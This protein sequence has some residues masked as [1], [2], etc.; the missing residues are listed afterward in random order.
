RASQDLAAAGFEQARIEKYIA[1]M[2]ELS[3]EEVADPKQLQEHSNLIAA[4]LALKPNGDCVKLAPDQ[5]YTCLTQTGGQSL[6]D[7]GHGQTIVDALTSGASAGLIGTASTTQL[8]G[9]GVYSAYVELG[10]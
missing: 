2:R 9:G 5:Q 6:L 1:T 8:A 4:R 10:G 7:D 3:P